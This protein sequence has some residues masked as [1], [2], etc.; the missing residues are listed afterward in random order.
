[1]SVDDPTSRFLEL[2]LANPVNGAILERAGQLAVP[3]WWLT[4]GALFQTVWNVQDGRAPSA[5]IRDYDLFYFDAGDLSWE[6][7]DRV[8]S[9]A[10]L[11]FADLE[12]TVEVRNEARVHL[13]YEEHFGVPA[14]PFTST[15]DAIDHFAST[16]CCYAVTRQV[17]DGLVVYAPHG[18][19]DLF[20]QRVRPNPRLAPREVYETK[21]ARWLQQWPGLTVD[22]WP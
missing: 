5:G 21:A 3:D 9:L 13:W 16:T 22:P 14:Q 2:A 20:A 11:L 19:D 7:E 15:K 10:A 6:A 18:Y 12:A 8:I 4:A 1:V 17:D